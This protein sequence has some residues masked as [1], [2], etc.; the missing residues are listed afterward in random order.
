MISV[1][2]FVFLSEHGPVHKLGIV[3]MTGDL[4]YQVCWLYPKFTIS[5]HYV[6]R[7]GKAF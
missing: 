1:G 5:K 2:D 4:V 3:L 6:Y 7:L